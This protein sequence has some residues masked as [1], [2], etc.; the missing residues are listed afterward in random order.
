MDPAFKE[1]TLKG[2]KQEVKIQSDKYKY[3][4]VAVIGPRRI[5]S[6][7]LGKRVHLLHRR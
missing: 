1:V 2:E 4:E 6:F 3:V 5:T 7:V